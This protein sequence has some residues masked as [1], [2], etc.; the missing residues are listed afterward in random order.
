[1]P[2]RKLWKREGRVRPSLVV[3]EAV[4]GA[5]VAEVRGWVRCA[6]YM[7]YMRRDHG[8]VDVAVVVGLGVGVIVGG[9]GFRCH[10]AHFLAGG[11]AGAGKQG[12]TGKQGKRRNRAHGVH[13]R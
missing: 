8:A 13:R 9:A 5:T 11:I 6:R 1:M 3:R 4:V 10:P 2:G 7:R 12:Q